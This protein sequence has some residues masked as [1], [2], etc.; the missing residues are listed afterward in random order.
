MKSGDLYC[1]PSIIFIKNLVNFFSVL[2]DEVRGIIIRR[3]EI[4]NYLQ[5][6]FQKLPPM[7]KD[8][9]TCCWCSQ[10]ESCT[11]F[12][13]VIT[14]NF[15]HNFFDRLWKTELLTVVVLENYFR[16]LRII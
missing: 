13:K 7:L 15:F 2:R 8:I 3:N 6:N 1:I 12:H 5:P 14:K 10:L 16:K 11:L 9:R 4:A